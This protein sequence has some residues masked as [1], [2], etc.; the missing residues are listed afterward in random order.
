MLIELSLN[1]FEGQITYHQVHINYHQPSH[2]PYAHN[3]DLNSTEQIFFVMIEE[4]EI[5]QMNIFV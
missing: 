5:H 2:K 3:K 4:I 1:I